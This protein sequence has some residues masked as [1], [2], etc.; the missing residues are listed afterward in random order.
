M[1]ALEM[2]DG[3]VVS[4]SKEGNEEA[5]E[6]FN[7]YSIGGVGISGVGRLLDILLGAVLEDW[8][9]SSAID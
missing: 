5:W 9:G 7:V 3:A 2:D 1:G 6:S 8:E 4:I